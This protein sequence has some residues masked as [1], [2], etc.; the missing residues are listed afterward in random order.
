MRKYP[1][2]LFLRGVAYHLFHAWYLWAPCLVALVLGCVRWT[3]CFPIAAGFFVA[4]IVNAYAQERA[5]AR[6][7]EK[8]DADPAFVAAV[9]EEFKK[10]FEP[11]D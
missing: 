10:R 1:G 3:V 8:E 9:D 5:V 4:W 11:Q 2:A 7:Y 6:E